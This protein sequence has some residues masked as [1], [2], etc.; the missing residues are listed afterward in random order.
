ML[1]DSRFNFNEHVQSKMNKCYKIIELIKKLSIH[2]PR[3]ALIRN[4]ES[5]VRPNLEYGD[6][7]FNKPKN[8]SFKSRIESIQ[9]KGCIAITG[10]IQ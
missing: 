2:L 7:I 1:L 6:I 5:F 9:Y 8:E 4:Y 10:A 3:E